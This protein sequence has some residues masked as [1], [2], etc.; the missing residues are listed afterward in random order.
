MSNLH[1]FHSSC[2]SSK[3]D[4]GVQLCYSEYKEQS[5]RPSVPFRRCFVIHSRHPILDV[6]HNQEQLH[7][8]V[9]AQTTPVQWCGHIDSTGTQ[10]IG[11]GA[12]GSQ[13]PLEMRN[14]SGP[15]ERE[16]LKTQVVRRAWVSGYACMLVTCRCLSTLKPWRDPDLY[17][18]DVQMGL[19]MANGS[20]TGW[21]AH[22]DG[23]CT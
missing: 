17:L 4:H 2:E 6:K 13:A 7:A 10:R 5:T 16:K 1:R 21:G 23:T 11:A 15:A 8:S 3:H 22:C 14:R 18:R 12:R 19:V 9:S 20:M